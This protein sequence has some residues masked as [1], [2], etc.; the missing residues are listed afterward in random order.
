[1]AE[2]EEQGSWLDGLTNE[3]LTTPEAKQS[4]SKYNSHEDALAGTLEASRM[5]GKKTSEYLTTDEGKRYLDEQGVIRK[6]AKDAKPEDVQ[7]YRSSM[8]KELGA[9]DEVG[10]KDFNFTMG[11]PEGH[12]AD[13]A[14]SAEFGKFIVANQIPKDIAEKSVGFVNQLGMKYAQ[15]QE[16]EFLERAKKSDEAMIADPSIGSMDNLKVKDEMVRRMFQNDLELSAEEYE[17][18]APE[19]VKSGFTQNQ[20]LRK[21]LYRIADKLSSTSEH[22]AGSGGGTPKVVEETIQSR[23]LKESPNTSKVLGW[24]K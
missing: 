14:I 12:Q 2:N 18:I 11:L 22:L 23:T 17:A 10:L 6:P 19:L 1:M 16:A 5:V 9:V 15:M 24:T 20:I 13:P 4:L 7:S 8:L 21:T 3:K